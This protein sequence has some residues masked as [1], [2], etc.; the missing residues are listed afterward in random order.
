MDRISVGLTRR[1]A[2][3]I[4]IFASISLGALFGVA[5]ILRSR[6][7]G[8]LREN[9]I[10]VALDDMEMAILAA[11]VDVV[12]PAA[13][14]FP[15][16]R[17]IGLV[18]RIDQ[19]IQFADPGDQKKLR[20]GLMYLEFAPP[21]LGFAHR[22]TQMSPTVQAEL[23]DQGL[24]SGPGIY[25]QVLSAFKQVLHLYYYS[26]PSVWTAI[27]YPGPLMPQ[28]EADSSLGY[29]ELVRSRRQNG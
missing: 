22:F 15:S 12:T 10:P 5:K 4:G 1:S 17:S 9:E 24:R 18:Q 6:Y 14:P 21:L 13:N 3:K 16:G 27:G 29:R 25:A 11:L 20:L 19:E 8:L 2:I 23:V 7:K 28:K 26:H